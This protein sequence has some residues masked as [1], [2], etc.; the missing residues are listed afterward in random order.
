VKLA[1]SAWKGNA[2][3]QYTLGLMLLDGRNVRQDDPDGIKWLQAAADGGSSDAQALLGALYA[4]GV[5]LSKNNHEAERWL[6]LAAKQGNVS[7]L[8]ML[9]GMY[10]DGWILTKDLGM[11]VKCYIEAIR[12]GGAHAA[13]FLGSIYHSGHYVSDGVVQDYPEAAK[14]FRIAT[15]SG[16]F[17]PVNLTPQSQLTP[18]A[19]PEDP[20]AEAC[21]LLGLMYLSGKGVEGDHMESARL[22][23]LAATRGNARG[24]Y[25]IGSAY[26]LGKGITANRDQGMMWLKRAAEQGLKEAQES[27]RDLGG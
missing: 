25:L 23:L 10:A 9:G 6:T 27:L 24:Q 20:C 4:R 14:W 3:D 13:L 15:N 18:D 7:A 12:R 22:F 2:N 26:L 11:A 21:V 17:P 19:Y 1:L 16:S 5:V 8:T